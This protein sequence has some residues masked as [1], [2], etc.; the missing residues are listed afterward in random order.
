MKD[1]FTLIMILLVGLGL[2]V[3]A[4]VFGFVMGAG[5]AI[6]ILWLLVQDFNS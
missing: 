4:P 6:Y 2:S 3:A 5:A 1:F